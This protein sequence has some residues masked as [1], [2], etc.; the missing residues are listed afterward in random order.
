MKNLK[1]NNL[2]NTKVKTKSLTVLLVT[3]LLSAFVGT[4][5][6]GKASA[7]IDYTEYTGTLGDADWALRIP[8]PW[9]GMLVIYCR[10]YA[11]PTMIPIL[12]NQLNKRLGPMLDAGFAG[13]AANYG[14]AGFCIQAGVDSTYEL[15][16]YLIDNYD[17][18][19]KVFLYGLSMGGAVAL[20]LGEKYP[21]V[22]SGVLDAFGTKDFGDQYE[23]KSRW[24]N[25]TDEELTEEL[26]RLGIAVPP[27]GF[28]SVAALRDR[29]T[30]DIPDF[31]L[32]A[33]GTTTT[34]PQAYEDRSPVYHADIMIPVITFHGTDDP[35]VPYYESLM[36][37]TAVAKAYHSS[38]YRLYAVPGAGHNV[39]IT[40]E[41]TI[42]FNELVEWSNE[43]TGAHDWPTLGYDPQ[44]SGY[45]TSNAPN[46]NQVLWTSQLSGWITVHPAVVD[47]KLYVGDWN[48]VFYCLDAATGLQVWNYTADMMGSS[49]AVA[50][51]KV[52]FG[53]DD[54]NFY[55]LDAMTGAK[56]WSYKTGDDV[57]S[58]PVVANGKVYVG[59]KDDKL[60]C[61][62]ADY[63]QVV[64]KFTTG[65]DIELSSPTFADGKVYVG[66][67][68]RKVY[69]VDAE[70]GTL[71][72]SYTTGAGVR[73]S[74]AVVDG[75]VYVGSNDN[76]VYC[77]DSN[78]GARVWSYT[79]DDNITYSS[80]AIAYGKLYVGSLDNNIY[81]L[82]AATGALI[83][84]YTTG[85]NIWGSPVVADGKVY[86]GSFDRNF[87]CLDAETGAI[88][89]TYQTNGN[90]W[91]G[92]VVANGVA[93]GVSW[94]RNVYAFS[95]WEPIPE[96]LTIGVMLL[97]STLA[98][99]VS[100]R[101]FR[102]RQKWE[103][104]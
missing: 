2:F 85:D 71:E 70:S 78:T 73:S 8:E 61:F 97:L 82:D 81:C 92:L 53:T 89:W 67:M 91:S 102:K 23:T 57:A 83:W 56:I 39:G 14:S 17:F 80:P 45:T 4:L 63:G 60:Y 7:A 52:Y 94:D 30:P 41:S 26:N 28:N 27:P 54:D 84:N 96:G 43:L 99:V 55:C 74:P 12:R 37:Q 93:Y 40:N 34:H 86:I 18:N 72:W 66:S 59:S 68:D 19:G 5:I 69:C 6:V 103:N 21:D 31:V 64:W 65:G 9:N 104:W 42:Y 58:S 36:Y 32:E 16:M 24:A 49:P 33:G 13:A 75:K 44:R 3:F 25:M 15:T 46:T 29:I 100:A 1:K 90:I 88:V 77:L 22:Y 10:G 87:Y 98:V 95:A 47:G 20:L 50:N 48:G 79:A 62:R 11:G 51:G 101:Y 38:L 35:I 76:N